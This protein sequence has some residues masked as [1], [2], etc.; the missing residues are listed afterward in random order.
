MTQE[1]H[2]EMQIRFNCLSLATQAFHLHP[3]QI[4]DAANKFYNYTMGYEVEHII[5]KEDLKN[6][7]S[8]KT[9]GIKKGDTVFIPQE[10]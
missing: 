9:E 4:L 6:N 10:N 5:T 8:L 3:E 2:A 1:Q 7:P